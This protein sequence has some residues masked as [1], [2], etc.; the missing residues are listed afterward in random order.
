M[1]IVREDNLKV[2]TALGDDYE[3]AAFGNDTIATEFET[4]YRNTIIL[5]TG[6][7]SEEEV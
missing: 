1:R 4:A 2:L 5:N 6:N 7:I 3:S